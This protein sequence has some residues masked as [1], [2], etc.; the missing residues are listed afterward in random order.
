MKANQNKI[1]S[2][3]IVVLFTI[4]IALLLT[5]SVHPVEYGPADI[6]AAVN[7]LRAEY[8]LSAYSSSGNLNGICQEQADYMASINDLTHEREDGTA[9]PTTAENIAYGPIDRAMASWVDDQ[10]HFDTLTAWSAGA[11]GAGVAEGNGLVYICFNINRSNDAE[12]APIPFTQEPG[13]PPSPTIAPT[14]APVVEEVQPTEDTKGD[15][16]VEETDV[17]TEE[18]S[19]TE[20]VIEPTSIAMVMEEVGDGEPDTEDP[21]PTA[22]PVEIDTTS[23]QPQAIAFE[24]RTGKTVAYALM[25]VGILGLAAS[26]YGMMWGIKNM[27]GKKKKTPQN[28]EESKKESPKKKKK[29][30]NNGKKKDFPKEAQEE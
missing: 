21:E 18:T 16:P 9:I 30:K 6:I 24:S 7:S 5:A 10:P 27:G 3:G 17:E 20:D 14:E 1:Y 4:F 29:R 12:Y 2:K 25:G 15:D 8:G 19:E 26:I 22:A 13:E 11:A 28:K 23:V